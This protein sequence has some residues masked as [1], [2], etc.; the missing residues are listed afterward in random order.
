RVGCLASAVDGDTLRIT[1]ILA[2]DAGADSL[3]VSA[4]ASLERCGPPEWQ[5]TVHTHI[6][7]ADGGRP[8]ALFSGADRGVM[9]MWWQRW[10]ADGTFCLL[11][12]ENEAH[13]E[14]DGSRVVILPSARY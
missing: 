8:Y 13:C 6:A 7:R 1:R 14:I 4:R 5:G 12:A 3:A 10:R 2:L 11:Y 9:L